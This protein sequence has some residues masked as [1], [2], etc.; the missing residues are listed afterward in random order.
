MPSRILVVDDDPLVTRTFDELLAR[1]GHQVQCAASG[2]EALEQLAREPADVILLD[3]RLPG[4][5]GYDTCALI[6]ERLGP[7]VP[8]L[9]LTA[10]NDATSARRS[11]DA[12]ADDFI[13]KPVDHSALVLKVRAFLRTKQLH[14]EMLRTREEARA[15]AR[16]MA[17]LH[18]IGR[19]WSLIEEPEAFYRMVTQRLAGLIG[20]PIC[21]VALYDAERKRLEAA[22]PAHGLPDNV[23][24]KIRHTDYHS[25]WSFESGRP[26][27]SNRARTD[28]RLIPELIAAV[29]AESIV[30]VPMLS[31]G[32]PLGILVAANKPGGFTD[33]D[34]DLLSIFAGPAA[35]FLRS[36]QIYEAQTRHAA[37]LEGLPPLMGAMAGTTSRGPLLDLTTSMIQ[38]QLGY[39]AVGFFAPTDDEAF[40]IDAVAG[41][42]RPPGPPVDLERLRWAMRGGVALQSHGRGEV[43]DLAVPVGSGQQAQGV[44]N[45]RRTGE[46]FAEDEVALLTA[47]AGQLALALQRADSIA[48][49]ERLARQMA[50]LYDLG[51]ETGALRDLQRLFV[52]ATE[53]GG[54]LIRADHASALR[55]DESAGT[56]RLFAAWARD[57]TLEPYAEPVFK[58]GE[59]IAGRVARDWVPAMVNDVGASDDFVPK[60]N[61]LSRILC[62]PVT[63]FDQEK[64]GLALF[65]V[66]NAT[67]RPGSARFTHDDLDYVTRFAGQL[68]IAVANSMAFAAER[69]RSEQLALVNAV[70]REIAGNLSRERILETAVRRIHEAFRFGLVMIG[71]PDVA[72]GT[73]RTVAAAG[74]EPSRLLREDYPLYTGITGRAMREKRTVIVHDV[75]RDPD[76]VPIVAQT[77]SEV[78]IPILL[79]SEVT[80]V[81]NVESDQP[82]A[83]GRSQVMTLETLA[84]GIGIML[85]NA[86]LYQA[87]EETNARL[88][89]LDRLKSEVV[90]VVAHD[91]RAPL[92]G[93][94]GHA[95]L[96]EWKPDAPASERVE[97]AQAIVRA[98]T[99]MA[100]LVDKTLKTTRLETGHFPF[101]FGLVDLQA[102]LREVFASQPED[103]G[104]PLERE[105]P[106]EPLPLWAD[107]ER[108]VEVIENLLSNA[109]KY[110]PAGG[111]VRVRVTTKDDQ[112]SVS[113]QDSGLGIASADLPRLFRPFSRLRTPKTASIEGSGLG[114]YIC[115]RIVKAH[116]GR[117]WAES[118]P[119][120]GSL[121]SFTIPLFGAEAQ[122]RPP[123]V[124]VAA[125]DE[126]TR[127]EVRRVTEE[128]GYAT[129]EV[130]DGVEAV[131][132]AAR[133][134]P[135]AIVLD[136]IL[137]RLRGEEVA[138]RLR[139]LSATASVPLFVLAAEAEL[140]DFTHLFR[141]FLPKP[142]DHVRLTAA[143][144]ALLAPAR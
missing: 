4:I 8:V 135:V 116:G 43:T 34:A 7:A 120:K 60:G 91:F 16:D 22:V 132:A 99:H 45:I 129:L 1:Q 62:V 65:G 124:L 6:R 83:F 59:G 44:L 119:D 24:R 81:L 69:E 28:P 32:A 115:E 52:K 113:V 79:G 15:R 27:V 21:L 111:A 31:E 139:E 89:E 12:G 53:E 94:L 42:C 38:K 17:L 57:P 80:A 133:L 75:S 56:L 13:T 63:Y 70:I 125:G 98:A 130:A 104:H 136:R 122:L 54:R 48:Q 41:N 134:R 95:E 114:L 40:R 142:L 97:S 84:D 141:A 128:L 137:P 19:D 102:V 50:T 68:S 14:D 126:A 76:Y 29:G 112:V 26:Y 47:L 73:E 5:S 23:T 108:L 33:G 131:E 85:R 87:I 64:G 67:R 88:V 123:L 118:E 96:L 61:P 46:A 9:M 71:I 10:F 3:V 144:Q 105:L 25:L 106:E 30:L 107:R 49:T 127:R 138:E 117:L 55:F 109:S 2:E 74:P 18:E 51:L 101:E 78:A 35:T 86:E 11:Y 72:T 82:R 110:S 143:L 77:R 103:P 100:S 37:R 36:R 140:G 20:A 66:L 90:N 121:F 39:E 92:A 58:L 93:V